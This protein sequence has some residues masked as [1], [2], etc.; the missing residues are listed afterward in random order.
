[1]IFDRIYFTSIVICYLYSQIK[2]T[3]GK[4]IPKDYIS[5]STNSDIYLLFIILLDK[6]L[7][8]PRVITNI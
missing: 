8:Y 2:N 4:Y 6:K 1:M 3:F 5:V 7:T